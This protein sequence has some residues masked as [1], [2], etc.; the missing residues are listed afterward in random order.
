MA[1]KRLDMPTAVYMKCLVVL[2]GRDGSCLL[3]VGWPIL[4]IA[5]LGA[6]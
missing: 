6:D 4:Y 2:A 5:W 3:L 1:M